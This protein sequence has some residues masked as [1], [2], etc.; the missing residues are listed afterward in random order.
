MT[1]F[2]MWIA[3]AVAFGELAPEVY[4]AMQRAA[5]EVLYVE[6][7]DVD[8]DRKLHKPS[9]CGFFEFEVERNVTMQVKVLRVVRSRTGVRPGTVITVPYQSIRQCSG[10]SGARPIPLLEEGTKTYAYLTAGRRGFGPAA[11]GASFP[12]QRGE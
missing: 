10:F 8:I 2:A 12:P 4:Q 7:L 5:P 3:A 11:R 6:V 9:G 1:L